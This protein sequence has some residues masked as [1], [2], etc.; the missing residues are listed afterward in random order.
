M[1]RFSLPSFPLI[2]RRAV[3]RAVL[4]GITAVTLLVGLSACAQPGSTGA[5]STSATTAS[6]TAVSAT[7]G[8]ALVATGTAPQLADDL[9]TGSAHHSLPVDGENFAL[10]VD[11]WT[12]VPVA[13]WSALSPA[14]LHVAAY[15]NP[16]GAAPIVLIDRFSAQWRLNALT[17]GLDGLQL[18]ETVD[19]PTGSSAG[20]QITKT[21][22]YSTVSDRTGAENALFDRWN[23]LV[24]GQRINAAGLAAAGVY[25]ITVNVRY[26]LLV[27]NAGDTQWHRRTVVDQLSAQVIRA[28]GVAGSPAPPA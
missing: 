20:F 21:I 14:D 18:L 16:K 2:H 25:G 26:D 7:S 5:G 23:Q 9:V 17:P 22:S 1:K 8:P 11:Y 19:A 12:T 15:L 24:S 10:R 13:Q 4:G 6:T 3:R 27:K 28:A